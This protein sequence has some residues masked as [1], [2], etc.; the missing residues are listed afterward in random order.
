MEEGISQPAVADQLGICT[1]VFSKWVRKYRKEG[2][3]GFGRSLKRGSSRRLPAPVKERIVA[4]KEAQPT[5]GVQRIS[6]ILKRMF[7]MKASHETVRR[8]L[9][10]EALLPARKPQSLGRSDLQTGKADDEGGSYVKGPNLMW[11]SDISVITWRSR[12]CI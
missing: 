9:H 1:A 6:D 12:A 10:E 4:M 11:Q 8:V 3:S 2:P 5:H 7:F